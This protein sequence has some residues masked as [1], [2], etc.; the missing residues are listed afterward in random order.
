M[1]GSRRH[2]IR[3]RAESFKQIKSF[4]RGSIQPSFRPL[5]SNG[6]R[7]N[8]PRANLDAYAS[9]TVPSPPRSWVRRRGFGDSN[10]AV[11]AGGRRDLNARSRPRSSH[12]PDADRACSMTADGCAADVSSAEAHRGRL[13][14]R[15]PRRR[16]GTPDPQRSDDSLRSC[17][18]G[19]RAPS[20]R[21]APKPPFV[22]SGGRP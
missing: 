20:H 6:R 2:D 17:P 9:L 1:E 18:T 3:R 15:C 4:R 13:N 19:G 22:D 8:H 12:R 11:A 7:I 5:I 21:I 14:D 16:T 10:A